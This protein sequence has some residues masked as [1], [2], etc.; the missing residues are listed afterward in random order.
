MASERVVSFAA[1]QA[2]N[3]FIVSI[4]N[5]AGMAPAYFTPAGRPLVFLYT[6]LSCFGMINRIQEKQAEGKR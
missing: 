5:R 6:I 3:D 2:S 4:S 1:A